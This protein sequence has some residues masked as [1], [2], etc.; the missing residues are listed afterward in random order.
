MDDARSSGIDRSQFR[1]RPINEY[2]DEDVSQRNLKKKRLTHRKNI[3]NHD[4][5]PNQ[6][7]SKKIN[8]SNAELNDFN[9]SGGFYNQFQIMSITHPLFVLA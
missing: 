4:K 1:P 7:K 2:I 6:I 3:K 5:N 9:L 8:Y